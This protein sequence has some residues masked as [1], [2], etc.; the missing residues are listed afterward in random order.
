[1]ITRLDNVK[2]NITDSESKLLDIARK[3][4]K[5]DV[6]YFKILKKSLDARDK[7]NIRWVYSVEFSAHGAE[8][9]RPQLEKLKTPPKVAVIGSGPSG[10]FC[11]VRLIEHGF[12]PVIIERGEP[13]EARA[14]TTQSFFCGGALN[15]NSNVQF[16]EGG[17]GTFSYGM[18]NNQKNV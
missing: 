13:V 5:A 17:A 15:T 2:L 6:K 7:N 14:K 8:E 9:P 3:N 1:M 11:A 16:G 12:A 10:L 18:H 4:L